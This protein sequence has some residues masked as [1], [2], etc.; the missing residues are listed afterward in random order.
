MVRQLGI[1]GIAPPLQ[2]HAV[3][4]EGANPLA[5]CAVLFQVSDKGCRYGVGRSL[6]GL[7]SG[8]PRTNQAAHHLFVLTGIGS[9][10]FKGVQAGEVCL[11]VR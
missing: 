4:K 11:S 1:S 10:L 9:G 8:Q 5:G 6:L 2:A 3:Q 7:E